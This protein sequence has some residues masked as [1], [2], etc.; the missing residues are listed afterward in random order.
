M[1]LLIYYF[2][3]AKITVDVEYGINAKGTSFEIIR[4]FEDNELYS[5][6]E[7]YCYDNGYYEVIQTKARTGEKTFTNHGFDNSFGIV[8]KKDNGSHIMS[9]PVYQVCGRTEPH[10][11]VSRESSSVRIAANA[12]VATILSTIIGL[13]NPIAG[14]ISAAYSIASALSHSNCDYVNLICYKYFI[15]NYNVNISMNCY[16]WN[17]IGY[18]T[19][20][21]GQ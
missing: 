8:S 17:Y 5:V 20:T 2:D 3:E 1:I 6:T 10:V 11:L 19:K 15:H 12:N 16:H 13:Y 4:L 21:N 18:V 7:K 9:T 14:F